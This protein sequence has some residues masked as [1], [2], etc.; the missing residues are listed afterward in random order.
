MKKDRKRIALSRETVRHLN[1]EALR[2][3]AGGRINE[4]RNTEC[5]CPTV[6]GCDPNTTT[7]TASRVNTACTQ[8]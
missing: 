1:G 5:E 7:L 6:L 8:P 3:I 4:S 2:G